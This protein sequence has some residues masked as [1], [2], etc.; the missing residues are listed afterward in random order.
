[1]KPSPLLTGAPSPKKLGAFKPKPKKIELKNISLLFESEPDEDS[2]ELNRL[3]SEWRK[4]CSRRELEFELW[5]LKCGIGH[6]KQNKEMTFQDIERLMLA[7]DRL[8]RE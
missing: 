2:E 6:I 4:K 1:M 3:E 8:V 7:V 5:I